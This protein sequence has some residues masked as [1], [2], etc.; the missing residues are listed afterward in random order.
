MF[1]HNPRGDARLADGRD[2][3][4]AARAKLALRALLLAILTMVLAAPTGEAVQRVAHPTMP[5]ADS[6]A[7]P[8]GGATEDRLSRPTVTQLGSF[9]GISYVRYD[10]VFE[11]AT[12]TGRFRVPYRISAPADTSRT[13]GTVVVE[14]SHF[15][16]G[17]GALD[18]YLRPDFLF[19]RGFVHAGIGWSTLGN[20][21]LDPSVPGTFIEGGVEDEGARTDDEIITEFAKALSQARPLVG[22][23]SR[24]YA[25]G[26]S[27]SS[28]PIMRL[29]HSGAANGVFDLAV[30]ITTEGFDPQA[31]LV[32]GRYTGKIIVVNSEF[33]DS[34]SLL[35]RGVAPK[36]YRFYVVAG[37][38]HIPD[39]LDAPLDLP[40]PV[41][42]LTPATFVP[43]L[44]AH[45]L[46]GHDW[47]RKNSV[48]PTSTQLRTLDD[49]TIARDATGNAITEDR[50]GRRVPRLPFVELGEARFITGFV[51][52]YDN[53]RT[54]QQLGFPTHR[55]YLRAFAAKLAAYEKA[56]YIL[57]EDAAV[58]LRR[59]SLCPPLT[60]TETYRDH[61][62][63]FVAVR[64]C[65]AS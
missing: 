42:G 4:G 62:T 26:F 3:M 64:P 2:H 36:R 61:Y 15:V 5:A 43:A 33:D 9:G 48:P 21:I 14:P 47:V 18:V 60:F 24:R 37:S 38:P 59:A 10:G 22:K 20:R 23:V 25:T 13:N 45:F 46:Q 55:A 39:P 8:D 19:R 29:I 27:D 11:G 28:Y 56:R 17:L 50:T 51:G 35:D 40:F 65:A 7:T 57:P 53:V 49:G 16:V 52:S 34:T 54:V 12:S 1:R 41:R 30:P 63:D 31:D 6:T 58:M 44:R 32:A